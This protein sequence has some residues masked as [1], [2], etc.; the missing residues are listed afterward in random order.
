MERLLTP[1]ALRLLHPDHLGGCF[2]FNAEKVEIKVIHFFQSFFTLD[3]VRLSTLLD[4]TRDLIN[5]Q[6]HILKN[7]PLQKTSGIENLKVVL[8]L[9]Y[10]SFVRV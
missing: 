10:E 5:K 7:A 1:V 9:A 8:L 4:V 6:I 3:V 2:R